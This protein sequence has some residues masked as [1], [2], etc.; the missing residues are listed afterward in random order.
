MLIRFSGTSGDKNRTAAERSEAA[1]IGVTEL[2]F[3]LNAQKSKYPPFW[4]VI[5]VIE[6]AVT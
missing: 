2:V 5:V 3:E 6:T 4:N 1:K